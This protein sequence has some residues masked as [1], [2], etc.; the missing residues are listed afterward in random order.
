MW[1]L[2]AQEPGGPDSQ[3]TLNAPERG[4]LGVDLR[5]VCREP[6]DCLGGG[7]N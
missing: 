7:A 1:V 3:T 2:L 4:Q 6:V 5:D